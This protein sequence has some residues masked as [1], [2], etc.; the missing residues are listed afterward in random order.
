MLIKSQIL[1]QASGSIAGLTGSHNRGGMYFRARTI[2]TNPA[3]SFQ[4]TV[5]NIMGQLTAAWMGSLTVLQQHWWQVYD[6]NVTL[7]NALGDPIHIGALPHFIRSNVGRMQA[8]L[9]MIEDAPHI[10]N[11]GELGNV[12]F[13][14][15][16]D[17]Q[18]VSIAYTGA[19]AWCDEDDSHML[20]YASR[21]QN[22]TIN[23]FKGPYRYL[24][25]IDGNSITP[26]TPPE[27]LDSAFPIAAAQL[28][29]CQVRVS[30]ADGRLSTPFRGSCT[31]L[32]L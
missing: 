13:S 27:E 22:P 21:P 30:R 7:I 25:K 31:V 10:Y 26:P 17:D 9:A 24:G 18:K 12:A 1:T 15:T 4:V 6:D 32:A 28:V 8:G 16:A 2:P 29:Y 20:C 5:R 11:L 14:A 23:Y 3:P 19:D